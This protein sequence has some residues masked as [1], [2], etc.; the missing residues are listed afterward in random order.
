[1]FAAED[2]YLAFRGAVEL[3]LAD[4][5]ADLHAVCS[6]VHA[7]SA[8]DR[9]GNADQTLHATQIVFRAEGDSAAE[10]SSGVHVGK[11][12]FQDDFRVGFGELKDDPG[13]FAIADEQV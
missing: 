12:A 9:A 2:F 3:D 7:K 13:E 4:V 8:S 10:V 11:I 1:M 5:A 6:S